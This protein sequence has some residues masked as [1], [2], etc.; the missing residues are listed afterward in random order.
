MGNTPRMKPSLAL[1]GIEK[2]IRLEEEKQSN[3]LTVLHGWIRSSKSGLSGIPFKEFET[4]VAKIRHAFTAI[5]V[6]RGLLT[7]CNKILQSKPPLVYLQRN[8]VLRAA[9]M[10]CR[11]LLWESSDSPTQCRKLIGGWPDYIGVCDASSHGVGGVI[12]GENKSCVPTVFRWE[13]P[14]EVKN[15][16][17]NDAITNSD[18][19]MAGLLL[20]WLVMESVCGSLREKRVALFSDNSPTVGWV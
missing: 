15:L 4:V 19:E 7:P 18:I 9:I 13:W 14:Q 11:M 6:G 12:F 17:H 20:L 3:L 8:P 1:I 16:Y 10:G 5:P 2:T